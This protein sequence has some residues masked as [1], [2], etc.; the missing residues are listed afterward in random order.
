MIPSGP[1][2][3]WRWLVACW[4][5][6]LPVV[7]SPMERGHS[8]SLCTCPSSAKCQHSSCVRSF[9]LP[10]VLSCPPLF[11]YPFVPV[12]A[13]PVGFSPLGQPGLHDSVSSSAPSAQDKHPGAVAVVQWVGQVQ[14]NLW[15]TH[16]DTEA[17]ENTVCRR[18]HG[19]QNCLQTA[20]KSCLQTQKHQEIWLLPKNCNRILI[21]CFNSC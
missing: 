8:E 4:S 14:W 20:S 12:G 15:D 2:L 6:F 21:F 11:C 1:V 3:P 18:T 13:S 9:F 10:P 7:W 16:M 19:V 17:C 5:L